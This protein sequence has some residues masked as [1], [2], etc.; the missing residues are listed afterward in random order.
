MRNELLEEALTMIRAA[1][2]KPN[3]VCNR[4]W[5]V[6]WADRRGH[7]RSIVVAISP[8]GP[9]ARVQSRAMLRRLLAA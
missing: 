7:T 6:S 1:G 3:I 8:S 4:H 2:F 5:K 9:R